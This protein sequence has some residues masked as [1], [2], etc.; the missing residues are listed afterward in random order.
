MGM[1]ARTKGL[2][3]S[4]GVSLGDDGGESKEMT[5][6]SLVIFFEVDSLTLTVAFDWDDEI[7]SL[8]PLFF[9]G[10]AGLGWG[11]VGAETTG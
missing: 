11:R 8:P 1:F 4:V 3:G 9:S 10:L 5:V 6:G 2:T 7:D